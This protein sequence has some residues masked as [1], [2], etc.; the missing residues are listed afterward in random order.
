MQL[1]VVSISMNAAYNR[2]GRSVRRGA[3]A[4]R[5]VSKSKRETPPTD[6]GTTISKETR[7]LWQPSRCRYLRTGT[8]SALSGQD[9]SAMA[10]EQR[11][12]IRQIQYLIILFDARFGYNRVMVVAKESSIL[13][14]GY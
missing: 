3:A 13:N 1:T 8:C 7:E 11:F 2:T 9:I 5:V 14:G 4:V 12:T 10:T 6:C